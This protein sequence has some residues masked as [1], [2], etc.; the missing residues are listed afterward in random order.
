MKY[1]YDAGFYMNSMGAYLTI[2]PYL[3]Q[4]LLGHDLLAIMYDVVRG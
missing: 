1:Y 2:W 4:E 3:H